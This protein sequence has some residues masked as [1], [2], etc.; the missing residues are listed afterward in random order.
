MSVR[1]SVSP[2]VVIKFEASSVRLSVTEDDIARGYIDVPGIYRLSINTDR[3]MRHL[4]NIML[5]Y[6]PNPYIFTSIQVAATTLQRGEPRS[7]IMLAN[8]ID[9]LSATAAGFS[10]GSHIPTDGKGSVTM[11]DGVE[12]VS[13]RGSV[14]SLGYRVT[15]PK[16]IKPGNIS[17]PLTLSLQL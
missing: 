5:D 8:Y 14:T 17:V 7:D 13:V 3:T 16:K 1:A 10:D 6:E 15:L 9:T 4:A 12:P 11:F 2:T